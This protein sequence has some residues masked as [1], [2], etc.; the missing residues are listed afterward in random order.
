VPTAAAL[1]IPSP[2]DWNPGLSTDPR[3]GSLVGAL[4]EAVVTDADIVASLGTEMTPAVVPGTALAA[5]RARRT[6]DVVT[7]LRWASEH[8]VPVVP[9]G[10]GT[11]IS[12]GASAL[13]GSL[14][15]SL[16]G[17]D[18]I[19]ELDVENAVAVVEPGVI[20]AV[21]DRAAGEHG[22]MYAPDPGSYETSTI[23]GNIATNAGG[24]RCVR[25]G[26]TRESVLG[27][28]VVL[29]DG[30]LLKT[31]R[32]TAKGV[33]GY[34]L[35]SL[36]VGSE[37]TLGVVVSAVLKLHRRPSRPP[38]TFVATF[39]DL[40]DAGRAVGAIMS[41]DVVPSMLEL[42]DRTTLAALDSWRKTGLASDCAG[43]LIGQV[44]R[45]AAGDLHLLQRCLEAAGSLDVALT[46]DA[47]EAAELVNI[48][49]LAYPALE[50]LGACLVEDVC[51]PRSR[52]PEMMQTIAA[53]AAKY[54]VT[55]ACAGH[56]GDGN[57][58]PVFIYEPAPGAGVPEPVWAAA[59]E[60]FRAALD[61]GG[62]LTGEHGVGSLKQRWVAAELGTESLAVHASIKAALD[63]AGI[64][65]PGRAF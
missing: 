9:R 60:V 15:L 59:D 16:A 8:A 58:H 54:E 17:M 48:R 52:L 32:R 7:A 56:A 10:A 43:M 5:V 27:L 25:Y 38:A 37:G 41:S 53:I 39:S 19:T 1:G 61:L 50:R 22:L 65:N 23:G 12:G 42:L 2:G 13:E 3:V 34:D 62:T 11:S 33:V 55:V 45:P 18:D 35:T 40:A 57:V 49:R 51:V 30:R 31:G 63:P 20:T 28:E 29:A 36:F 14:V 24:L 46:E 4:G 47:R 26:V 44:D 64:L 6:S 21:L